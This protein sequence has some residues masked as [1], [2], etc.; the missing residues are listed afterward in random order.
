M[1]TESLD[2]AGYEV[3]EAG[4]AED[5]IERIRV[6]LPDAVLMDVRMPGMNGFKATRHLS[7]NPETAGIPIII[8][9]TKNQDTDRA[10]ALRQGAKDYVVKPVAADILLEKIRTYI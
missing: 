10:W 4:N 9:T 6:Q 3:V 2:Q 8:V 5:A 7:K 1:L